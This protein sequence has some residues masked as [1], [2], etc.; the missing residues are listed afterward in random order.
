MSDS[1]Q[2]HGLLPGLLSFT[3]PGICSN[4]YPLSQ[5]CYLILCC[6]LLLWP[7][8][9]PSIRVF[10]SESALHIRWAKYWS[11]SFSIRLFNEYSGL[12]S[13]R[14][15]WFDRLAVQGTLKSL[16]QHHNSKAS[17][18][19]LCLL[20]DPTLLSTHDYWKDHNLDYTTF[21]GKVMSLLVNTLSRFVTAFLLRNNCLPISFSSPGIYC[22][23]YTWDKDFSDNSQDYSHSHPPP[24]SWTFHTQ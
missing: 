4:S 9:F 11:F 16:L 17:S 13:F 6:P 23:G 7:S 3:S 10:S 8:F 1:L 21:V 2:P 20:Y 22:S 18:S 5:W 24:Y 14:I 12:V 19:M 15:N